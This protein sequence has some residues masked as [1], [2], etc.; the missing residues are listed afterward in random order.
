MTF[1]YDK[2]GQPLTDAMAWGKLHAD[3]AYKRVAETI[4]P[5]GKWVSTVWLGIDHRFGEGPPLIF[6]TM[7]FPS[8]D[9]LLHE[10]DQD[11]YSTE[12]EAIVGHKAMV[13]KWSNSSHYGE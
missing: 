9:G 3:P 7:I 1:Y 13:V 12:T 10:L 6:E 4:L 11:R 5:D 8:K 2:V